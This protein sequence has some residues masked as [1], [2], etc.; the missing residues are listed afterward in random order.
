M[1]SFPFVRIYLL[2]VEKTVASIQLRILFVDRKK[3][4]SNQGK[5]VGGVKMLLLLGIVVCKR[6]TSSVP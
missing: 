3:C 6:G 1:L 2:D 5:E 4:P